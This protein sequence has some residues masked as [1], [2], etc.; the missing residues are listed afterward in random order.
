MD[1]LKRQVDLDLQTRGLFAPSTVNEEQRTIELTWTTGASVQ[2]DSYLDGPYFEELDVSENSIRMGRLNSGAPLLNSHS[3]RNLS[4]Q[5]GVVERA[6][7]ENGVGKAV[8][9]FSGREEVRGIWDDVKSG[10]IRNVSV[11]YRTY[12]YE[13]VREEGGVPTYRA[14]DWEPYELSMVAVPADAASQVRSAPLKEVADITAPAGQTTEIRQ[15]DENKVSTPSEPLKGPDAEQIRAEAINAER[16]RVAAIR[17]A[18]RAA[19]LDESFADKLITEGIEADAARSAVLSELERATPKIASHVSVS[20]VTDERDTIR[21]G[22]TEAILHRVDP[23]NKLTDNGKR[24]RGMTLMELAKESLEKSGVSVRGLTNME[25]ATRAMHGTSDFPIITA[26]VANKTLR[27]GY[28]NA[29]RTFQAWARQTTTPDFKD[30]RRVQLG[31]A[32]SLEKVLEHGEFTR[33]TIAEG[34]EKY[35]IFTYG[36]VV[37][38]TRQLIINDDLSA[39][40]RVPE[41]FGRAAADLES[42]IVYS[43]LTKPYTMADNQQLF[44]ANHKNLGTA[45]PITI[46]SLD[47][48]RKSM[49]K[50]KGLAGRFINVQPR[51]LIVGPD[52]ETTAQQLLNSDYVPNVQNEIN[53]FAGSTLQL[54]VDP[55]IENGNWFVAADPAQIDTIEYCFLEGQAGVAIET[56]MGFDVDGMKIKVRH[57]FGAA[58]IDYRGL[59]KNPQA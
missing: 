37:A 15:M 32:P 24:F 13:K 7:I 58:P 21:A 1:D 41:L 49:R 48:A 11:G 52:N 53:P 44:S 59:F 3:A 8:V 31:D 25:V 12:T 36:K 35:R 14:V 20:T 51:Y 10:I 50:Q 18:V 23:A 40:T 42:D 2:R 47:E 46:A 28:E 57:D 17:Q 38:V 45:A 55:R 27:R 33:G 26:D 34:Q 56:E 39:F 6:W 16:G 30:I 19:K 22:M 54:I 29:A 4:D 9:R 43:L 5:I